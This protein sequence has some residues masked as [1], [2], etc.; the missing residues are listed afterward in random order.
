MNR[1]DVI[2]A[3][4]GIAGLTAACA[5]AH[6]G[7]AVTLLD[8][9][10]ENRPPDFRTTAFLQPARDL[11]AGI[12]VWDGLGEHPT[13]LAE[14]RVVDLSTRAPAV[15]DFRAAEVSDRPFG[16]NVVNARM[17]EA[18]LVRAEALGVER[19]SAAVEEVLPRTSEI[20]VTAGGEA[21]A[22][23]LLVGADGRESTVRRALG[24]DAH[25]LRTG[26]KAL[27]FAVEHDTP[28]EAV[29]TELYREGG[30]FVLVPLADENGRHRSAVVWMERGAEAQRLHALSGDAFAAA[31][32]ERSGGVLGALR[33]YGPRAL[34]PLVTRVADRFAGPRAALMAEA[35]HAVPPIGAQGLNMSLADVALL[36]EVS[37][38][39]LGEAPGLHRYARERRRDVLAR[40][41][42]VTALNVASMGTVAPLRMA[43]A[44]GIRALGA[45]APARRELMRR[46]MGA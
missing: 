32:T 6:D 3:G 15:A 43:R 25:T 5:L 28:H 42:A 10:P 2:V 46:G 21:L 29:S 24:I 37:R 38:D 23:A 44:L 20:R 22:A 1:T 26:Q 34:F 40:V 45:M 18:L 14:M 12:G 4:G 17:R 9:A 16:W 30:P 27:S 35:A 39:G 33:P 11:L 31:V 8:P 13:P 41:A 36:R 19:R 7:H